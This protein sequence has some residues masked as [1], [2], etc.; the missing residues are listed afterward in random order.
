[1]IDLTVYVVLGFTEENK[2]TNPMPI[3][4]QTGEFG[5]FVEAEHLLESGDTKYAR[6]EVLPVDIT[7]ALL[8][9]LWKARYQP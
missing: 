5:G 6:T 8:T 3:S 7:Q 9:A 4:L 1:M 2:Y